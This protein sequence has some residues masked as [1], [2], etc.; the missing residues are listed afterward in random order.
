MVINISNF[1]LECSLIIAKPGTIEY[2]GF[3]VMEDSDLESINTGTVQAVQFYM[4]M[5]QAVHCAVLSCGWVDNNLHQKY[6]PNWKLL[7]SA[8]LQKEQI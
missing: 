7:L 4:M 8:D 6:Y 1:H 2:N 3:I 5:K